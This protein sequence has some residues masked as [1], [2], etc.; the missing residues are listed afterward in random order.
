MLGHKHHK[1]ISQT[2]TIA[3]QYTVTTTR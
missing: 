1:A 2:F 3:L